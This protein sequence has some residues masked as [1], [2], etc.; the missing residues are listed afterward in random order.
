MHRC[1]KRIKKYFIALQANKMVLRRVILIFF[2]VKGAFERRNDFLMEGRQIFRGKNRI[3][4]ILI[5]NKYGIINWINNVHIYI[6]SYW[7]INLSVTL[8][9]QI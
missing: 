5:I 8:S 7:K 2:I 3:L 6:I 9:V 4:I 1:F